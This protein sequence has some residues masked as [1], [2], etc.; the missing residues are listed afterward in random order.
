MR[1]WISCPQRLLRVA[2]SLGIFLLGSVVNA[3][4]DPVA[5]WAARTASDSVIEAQNFSE[6]SSTQQLRDWEIVSNPSRMSLVTEHALSGKTVRLTTLPSDND[7]SHGFQSTLDGVNTDDRT[8]TVYKRFYFQFIVWGDDFFNWP[9]RSSATNAPKLAI[10]D[11]SPINY[12]KGLTHSPS[13]NP[14]EVVVDNQD[15]FGFI[16][17]YRRMTSNNAFQEF[18]RSQSSAVNPWNFSWHPSVDNG[19]STSSQNDDE[20]RYGPFWQ[21]MS[22]TSQASGRRLTEQFGN[23]YPD[24][25]AAAGSVAWNR[26]GFTVIEIFVDYDADRA[27]VWAAHYGEKPRLLIDSKDD[28]RGAAYFNQRGDG[29][30]GWDGYHLTTFRTKGLAEPGVRPEM[31]VDYAEVIISRK[32]IAFPGQLLAPL[33]GSLDPSGSGDTIAPKPPNNLSVD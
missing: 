33:P 4:I 30:Q 27:Q 6:F 19:G 32:P 25:D 8:P 12:P 3:A 15:T 18:S 1:V 31:Y 28:D 13:S 9:F 16:H 20:R 5:D 24:P 22:G 7:V 17:V 2:F 23:Q 21:G 11:R 29:I 10:I 26:G 14:G